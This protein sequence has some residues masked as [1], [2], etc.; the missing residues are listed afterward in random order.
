M[1]EIGG[2]SGGGGERRRAAASGGSK[3]WMLQ[4]LILF[5]AFPAAD[6]HYA[7]SRRTLLVATALLLAACA[8]QLPAAA[9]APLGSLLES[10][11]RLDSWLVSTRRAFHAQ[12]ELVFEEHNTSA[13]IR[14]HLDELGIRYK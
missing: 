2:D 3:H 4:A 9:A 5:P 6:T 7:M 11:A 8:V 13:A 12:P 1:A 10:A 14:Q